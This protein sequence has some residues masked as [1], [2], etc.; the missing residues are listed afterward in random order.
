MTDQTNVTEPLFLHHLRKLADAERKKD[1]AVA[2]VRAAR[3]GAKADGVSLHKLDQARSLSKLSEAEL[4]DEFN[5]LVR[6]AT[7]LN[8]PVYRQ[9]SLFELGETGDEEKTLE[10]AYHDGCRAGKLGQS[11]GS[12][13]FDATLP[14]GQKWL[15]GYRDGQAALMEG[16]KQL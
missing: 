10:R 3:K 6:Y 8:V 4:V 13:P 16:I 2:L 7:F 15:A 5:T 9:M 12:N 14:A 1:E 11:E